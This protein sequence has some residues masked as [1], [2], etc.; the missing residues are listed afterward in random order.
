M[1]KGLILGL[2]LLSVSLAHSQSRVVVVWDT[3]AVHGSTIDSLVVRSMMD[4]GIKALTDSTTVGQ[5]WKGI[6]PGL[7]ATQ[8]IALKLTVWSLASMPAHPP[9]T[10]AILRGLTQM[11]LGAT[12]FRPWRLI[13]FD[14]WNREFSGAGYTVRTDTFD[15]RCGGNDSTWGYQA[16]SYSIFGTAERFS[17]A[18]ADSSAFLINLSVLKDMSV[19]TIN[20]SLSMKNHY[21]TINTPGNLHSSSSMYRQVPEVV[22]VI[23]D[24]LG[25]KEKIYI[26]DGLFA[27]YNSPSS[28]PQAIPRTIL[29]SKDPVAIDSF[30]VEM[31]NNMRVAHGYTPKSSPY[32]AYA[33]SIGLGTRRYTL[34]RINNPSAVELEPA[35]EG[36]S[37][38]FALFPP[39]P[40]PFAG[41][42][43][44]PFLLPRAGEAMVEV[45][46]AL[47]G[48]VR[49]LT[50]GT[51]TAG[52]HSV[53]W[54]G[55][56]ESGHKAA[57]GVYLVRLA[58]GGASIERSLSLIR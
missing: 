55:R 56:D 14:R 20:F 30:G 52:Q 18:L 16:R 54:D 2:V 10:R 22:R 41:T 3:N 42:S 15:M 39:R 34:I 48:R 8:N 31:L 9:V 5:A 47:G 32:L 4:A 24:S 36:G 49:T 44:I 46:N 28:S 27:I 38:D 25:H 40:N 19:S 50:R 35:P 53:T 17:S 37:Y 21:G 26:I 43:E 29:L 57:S 23:R 11:Q 51:R 13:A 1:R 33:E 12:T 7:T 58:F 45:Y 6:F